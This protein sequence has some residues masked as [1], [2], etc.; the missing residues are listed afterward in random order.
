MQIDIK[1]DIDK[2]KKDLTSIQKKQIPAATQ[3][4]LNNTAKKVKA[5]EV[6]EIKKVFNRPT[7]F[8][9]NSLW[10]KWARKTKLQALVKLKDEAFKGNPAAKFLQPEIE[11]GARRHKGFEK[12]LI[13]K[14]QM[15]RNMYA[16][17]SRTIK[18]NQYGNVSNGVIQ[19]ILSGLSSQRDTYQNAHSGSKRSKTAGK[20][21]SGVIGHTH[22][23]WDIGRLQRGLPALLFIFVTGAPRY[24]ARF[25][26]QRVAKK[27]IGIVFKREFKKTMAKALA[28]AR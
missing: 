1:S 19:K 23:I 22:G 15:P 14:G 16:I 18:K 8:T 28:T 20:F 27:T 17:P 2:L 7:R 5:A 6:R 11:G 24:R 9:Q 4:A 13:S 3:W 10:I 25:N 26:F 12:L 21:F